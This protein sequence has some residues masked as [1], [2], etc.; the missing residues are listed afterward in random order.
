[1]ERLEIFFEV[2]SV[3]PDKWVP[4][5]LTLMGSKM[6]AL[7]RSLA[8][9]TKPKELSFQEILGTL[10]QQLDPKPIIIAEKF[11]FHKAGQQESESVRQYL[12]KLQTLAE[13]CEF[14]AYCDEAIRDR[15]VCTLHSQ[16]IQHKLLAEVLLTLQT[17]VEKACVHESTGK[18]AL[19][20]HGVVVN[21][22]EGN[23]PECFRCGQ[24]RP[25]R[26]HALEET[27]VEGQQE[28]KTAWPMFTTVDTQRRCKELKAPVRIEGKPGSG[29][30]A[31]GL[32]CIFRGG[33][34][35]ENATERRRREPLRGLGAFLGFGN[36]ISHVFTGTVSQIKT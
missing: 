9:P 11:K 31:R 24:K 5:I 23:F 20:L 2:N 12:A 13:M 32:A 7:L 15:F 21:K 26:I 33:H 10:A 6:F 4:S 25:R 35:V 17:A 14:G 27:G 36:A 18:E 1:M 30:G 22:V 19:A 3:P 8:V 29:H 34:T 16:S 28:D